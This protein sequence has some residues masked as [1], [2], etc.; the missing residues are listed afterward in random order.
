MGNQNLAKENLKFDIVAG[1]VVCLVALPLCLGIALASG[2][3]LL[4][5]IISGVIGGIVVGA[6]SQSQVG[7]SGPA[8]GL[9]VIVATAIGALG[10]EAFLLA[11][12]IAGV[13]QMIAGF[14]KAGIVAHFFPSSVIK[15]MLSG[16]GL[17][18]L[19][20]QIPHAIGFDAASWEGQMEFSQ[21]D[22]G[23]TFTSIV[24]AFSHFEL[25]AVIISLLCLGVIILMDN[26]SFEE[27]FPK[28]GMIPSSLVVVVL[29][30]GLNAIYFSFFPDLGLTST[31]LQNGKI[32]SHLVALPVVDNW[33]EYLAFMS[34]PKF[35]EI[36]NVNVWK[37]AITLFIVAS[38]ESLLSLEATDKI[39]PYRRHASTNRELVAQGVGNIIAGLVGGI[40]ITQV[41]VRSAA[42]VDSGGKTKTATIFHGIFLLTFVL[43]IP[44]ILNLIPLSCLAAILI[45]VGYKLASVKIIKA[46]INLGYSQYLPYFVTV[47]GL[48]FT[49]MLTGIG[50]G[51]AV[52]VF[53]ILRMN[54][55]YSFWDNEKLLSK[56]TISINLPQQ[57]N[58]LNAVSFSKLLAGIKPGSNVTID[59]AKTQI[60]SSEFLE[61]IKD[62]QKNTE[63][64]KISLT[65]KNIK[66]IK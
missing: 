1:L 31:D 21:A 10:I 58:F 48:V 42:N 57:V 12:I 14:I 38:L 16:I 56:K 59:G 23:N 15:G 35:S 26:K 45:A 3:S 13:F 47:F 37:V 54:Y 65:L 53:E 40:P 36:L 63:L 6:I 4:S 18:L 33:N 17:I 50:I 5:G 43:F 20:K 8:A 2:S 30:I 66:G 22:G 27:K 24:S 55:N 46:Q 29:G 64:N 32:V 60:M 19:L 41:V 34:F 39:D 28:I 52:A 7:V 25:G 61:V 49:D 51:M 11:V 44:K 9:A 62:F